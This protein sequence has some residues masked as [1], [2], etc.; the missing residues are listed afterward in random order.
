MRKRNKGTPGNET[1]KKSIVR[2]RTRRSARTNKSARRGRG[3]QRTRGRASRVTSSN[4]SSPSPAAARVDT[5]STSPPAARVDIPLR[6][7]MAQEGQAS[8]TQKR[9]FKV[10]P[11]TVSNRPL[12][13]VRTKSPK[14][15]LNQDKSK[16]LPKKLSM[17]QESDKSADIDSSAMK[18]KP[19]VDSD[20][21]AHSQE[22]DK[23]A[24]IDSSAIKKKTTV[25]SDVKAPLSIEQIKPK[26]QE[27]VLEKNKT[28]A[29]EKTNHNAN[30]DS[31][32]TK[33]TVKIVNKDSS[34]IKKILSVDTD[35]KAHVSTK[36]LKSKEPAPKTNESGVSGETVSSS[37]STKS[38]ASSNIENKIKAKE[39][40]SED[41]KES[42]IESNF[43][44]TSIDLTK[45]ILK[46]V[47]S[48][49]PKTSIKNMSSTNKKEDELDV[50]D[51]REVEVKDFFPEKE[52]CIV[53]SVLSLLPY[54]NELK[55]F[56]T[57]LFVHNETTSNW[58]ISDDNELKLLN[59]ISQKL[60]QKEIDD[61]SKTEKEEVVFEY[62]GGRLSQVEH[63]SSIRLTMK[64][65]LRLC[66]KSNGGW[67][68]D[69]IIDFVSDVINYFNTV[70]SG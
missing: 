35:I 17:P 51:L 18:K 46:K 7:L 42:Q 70:I 40:E 3:S 22:S 48:I 43:A 34:S 57:Q 39:E 33:E 28:Q 64:S 32:S 15:P 36:K 69:E 21:K 41:Q 12:K 65:M 68:G 47:P 25:D 4:P 59:Y 55:K 27:P 23:S 58:V 14:T 63:S 6:S 2:G 31:T 56:A 20:V 13:S 66:D 8:P 29:S 24:D 5:S 38:N 19:T 67:I 11:P 61:I 44:A 52:Q 9:K 50:T 26:E 45:D 30:I 49:L 1:E 62:I 54:V 53:F 60:F 10:V 16:V 37:S